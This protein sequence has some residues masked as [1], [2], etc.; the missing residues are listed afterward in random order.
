M[1]IQDN[2]NSMMT[3]TAVYWGPMIDDGFGG[4]TF[5]SEY[6]K[7]VNCRWQQRSDLGG[8]VTDKLGAPVNCNAVVYVSEDMAEE[9]WLFFG[10]LDDIYNL[11]DSDQDILN[12]KAIDGAFQIKRF[13]KSP[14]MRSND[15]SWIRK[16]YLGFK[17]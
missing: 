10:T 2:I 11:M 1:S 13:D 5:D 8:R 4:Q 15:N 7:E 12:P 17:G 14:S 6:P 16:V 3:Q 9:S